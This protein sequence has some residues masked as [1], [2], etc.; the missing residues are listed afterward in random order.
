MILLLLPNLIMFLGVEPIETKKNDIKFDIKKPLA[1]ITY[2]KNHYEENFGLK[3]TMIKGYIDFKINILNENP[4]QNRVTKG[5]DGWYFLG[6]HYNNLI[7]DHFGNAPFT[8][9]ELYSITN[10]ISEINTYLKSKNIKF[11]LVVPPNKS[12]IYNDKLPYQLTKSATRLDVLKA[13][14][15]KEINFEIIDLKSDLLLKKDEEQ[16]YYKTNT[17]WNDYG[18]YLGYQSVIKTL[19]HDF[20]ISK[21]PI[22]NYD[23]EEGFKEGDITAMIKNNTLEKTQ[24]LIKKDTS[25]ISTIV[26]TYQHL[27]FKNLNQPLK[28]LMY[29]DS[30]ANNWISYFNDSFG[31]TIYLRHYILDKSFIEKEQPDIVIFEI[32]ERNLNV[33]LN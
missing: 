17:H 6:N 1:S 4:I 19:N 22:S 2:F 32:V 20:N 29:R 16:L 30:F 24:Y 21:S 15:K 25:N 28:L 13:H 3:S 27:H 8:D 18:A 9:D 12:S 23:Y 14:L 33:L 7:N 5:R 10:H 26:N 31:E 11:Y